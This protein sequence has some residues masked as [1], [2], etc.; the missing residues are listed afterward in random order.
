MEQF[1]LRDARTAARLRVKGAASSLLSKVGAM[2]SG[3]NGRANVSPLNYTSKAGN[4]GKSRSTI[5]H[6]NVRGHTHAVRAHTHVHRK[7]LMAHYSDAEESV[8]VPPS[9]ENERRKG[10]YRVK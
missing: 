8:L 10:K 3:E 9:G 7:L 2:P 6:G 5:L 1:Y 4:I